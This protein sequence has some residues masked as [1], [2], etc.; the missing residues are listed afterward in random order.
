MAQNWSRTSHAIVDDIF[1]WYGYSRLLVGLHDFPRYFH[2][3]Q[4]IFRVFHYFS[5]FKWNHFQRC[6]FVAHRSSDAIFAMYRSSLLVKFSLKTLFKIFTKKF[7]GGPVVRVCANW[8]KFPA[9]LAHTGHQP[10]PGR[11]FFFKPF[12]ILEF[13]LILRSW[14]FFQHYISNQNLFDLVN[15]YSFVFIFSSNFKS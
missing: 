4:G 11:W 2:G 14:W 15:F 6:N 13:L 10:Q 3:S 1:R 9:H 5:F 12:F 7:Q 8:G